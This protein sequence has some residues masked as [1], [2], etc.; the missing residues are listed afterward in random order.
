MIFELLSNLHTFVANTIT[1]N[2]ISKSKKRGHCSIL[3]N[4]IMGPYTLFINIIQSE[5][6]KFGLG[7]LQPP[8]ILYK[9][10]TVDVC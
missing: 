7:L 2:K 3:K 6:G 1:L 8:A 4:L 5:K 10:L 9:D